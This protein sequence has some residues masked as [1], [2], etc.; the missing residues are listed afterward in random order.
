MLQ[1]GFGLSPLASGSITFIAAVGALFTKTLA[2]RVLELT[3]FR[4]L[5]V[6]NALIGAVFIGLNGFFTPSTPHW[7][8]MTILFAGGC[9][10]SMQF[11]S[12]NAI[13]YADVSHR[14]M[15]SATSLSSVAQQLS[16]SVGVALGACALEGFDLDA[17]RRDR[18][19]AGFRLRVLDRGGRSRRFRPSSSCSLPPDAGAEMSGHRAFKNQ[20]P[21][22]GAGGCG[23]TA[24]NCAIL[25]V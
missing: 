18:R 25:A 1:V 14:D 4:R 2:K 5:L 16:L 7:A 17:G 22:T 24:L 12:L 23:G 20:P 21:S 10:R 19:P 13:A 6:V 3:G 8:I 15:S 9:F 11:T